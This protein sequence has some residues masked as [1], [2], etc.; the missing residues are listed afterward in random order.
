[1][2]VVPPP[3]P[4]SWETELDR[5][6]TELERAELLLSDAT[7]L[8]T[9]TDMSWEP[10]RALGPIPL[11]LLDRARTLLRRQQLVC[12]A[13]TDAL[14]GVGRQQRYAARVSR[15]VGATQQPSYLDVSA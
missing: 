14:A 7:T 3:P 10:P 12:E 11:A 4:A 8:P 9:E 15:A 5:F 6:E 13:L 2:I 1:M